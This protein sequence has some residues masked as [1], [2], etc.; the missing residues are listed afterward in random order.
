MTVEVGEAFVAAVRAG[1]TAKVSALL[2]ENAAAGTITEISE[3]SEGKSLL[4]IA[5]ELGDHAMVEVLLQA[6]ANLHRLDYRNRSP[7][8]HAAA[9]VRSLPSRAHFGSR[10]ARS[11]GPVLSS[12]QST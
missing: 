1:D 10:A 9:K 3:D 4:M 8:T 7:L 12:T 2:S 6:G 11:R 5:A